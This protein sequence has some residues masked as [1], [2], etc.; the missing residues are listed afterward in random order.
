MPEEIKQDEKP[1][2]PKEP[3]NYPALAGRVAT[4][5]IS[6]YIMWT[7][8]KQAYFIRLFAINTYGRV[9][10]EF[11][12]WFNFRATQYL[13]DHGL[14][15]PTPMPHAAVAALQAAGR[16]ASFP[17]SASHSR[18]ASATSSPSMTPASIRIAMAALLS[19]GD[20]PSSDNVRCAREIIA[21]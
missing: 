21:G 14:G 4:L 18:S 3:T 20:A 6:C 16:A 13:A 8:M 15:A 17:R 9:I 11:D 10:H 5:L 19:S 1:A 7:A 12:P 2:P